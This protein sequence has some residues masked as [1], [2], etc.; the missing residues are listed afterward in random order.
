MVEL[1]VSKDEHQSLQN[2]INIGTVKMALLST[3]VDMDS[4]SMRCS[5]FTQ[6]STDFRRIEK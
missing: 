4:A 1:K 6:R 2:L 5:F 3:R